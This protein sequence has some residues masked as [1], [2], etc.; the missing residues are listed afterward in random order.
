MR[1]TDPGFVFLLLPAAAAVYYCLPGRLKAAGLAALSAGF[2]ALMEPGFAGW[3]L[4]SAAFDCAASA[5]A[6]SPRTPARAGKAL[7]IAAVG[8]DFTLM[9]LFGA[10]LP[11]LRGAGV[12]VGLMVVSLSSAEL[13]IS[14]RRGL[15][16]AL[17]PSSFAACALFFGRLVYGP[18]GGG[19]LLLP[20]L[21]KPRASLSRIGHGVMLL[22]LGLLKYVVL[23]R[24]LVAL[25]TS[26]AG[27]PASQ[28]SVAQGWAA[29]ACGALALVYT[30]WAYSDIA[31]GLGK[32]FSIELPATVRYPLQ[33]AGIRA[34]I[35]SFNAP[36]FDT[37]GFITG[38]Q[39]RALAAFAPAAAALLAGM[40]IFPSA[41]HLL[42]AAWLA[43]LT[44][45]DWLLFNRIPSG[46]SAVARLATLA[47]TLP[48][49]L[50]LLPVSLSSRFA[51]LCAMFGAGGA[52]PYND[53]VVYYLR[54]DLSL[55]LAALVLCWSV[56]ETALGRLKKRF[57]QL[58]WCVTGTLA[59]T[60]LLVTA[61]FILWNVR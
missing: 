34:C 44:P 16:P 59:L 43:L 13:L 26:L 1:L 42:W 47:V 60:A 39:G 30:L 18:A 54:S 27:L 40:W 53:A 37:A 3:L 35:R 38:R 61:S 25:C 6:T 29:A 20:Q 9:A 23:A 22:L 51:L 10:I 57:P 58:W 19:A 21:K 31:V 12:P 50:L 14:Q 41:D 8:K 11:L 32:I 7:F 48:G 55:L 36:L 5:A 45:L 56:W 49:Y 52:V 33:A 46:F 15:L 24:R 2:L 28:L 17:S 4:A